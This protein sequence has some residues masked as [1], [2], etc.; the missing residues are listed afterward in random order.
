M[1][2]VVVPTLNERDAVPRLAALAEYAQVVVADGGSGDGTPAVAARHGL[3]VVRSGGGRGRQM[4]D[5]AAATDADSLVFLHADTTLPDGWAGDVRR[6]LAAGVA[7]GAFSFALD[8]R[9]L[10]WRV[11]EGLT[12]LRGVPYGDQAL[13]LRRGTFDR[14]GGFREWPVLEDLDLVRRAGRLGPVRVLRRRAVSG[15][16]RWERAGIARTFAAN[17]ACL[18]GH[19]LGADVATLARLRQRLTAAGPAR[20]EAAGVGLAAA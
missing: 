20:P 13:F 11:V 2:A 4:N 16:R 19:R 7:L 5:G 9:G 1:I 8:A 3:A 12:R 18:L 10:R 6:T 17:Q 15:A 14:L